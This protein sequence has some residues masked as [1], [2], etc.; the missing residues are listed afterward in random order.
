[1]RRFD[2]LPRLGIRPAAGA[3]VRAALDEALREAEVRSPGAVRVLDAGCGHKSPLVGLRPRI[4]LLVGVDLHR[5]DPPLPWIDD[6]AVV[7]LCRP[8]AGVPGGG[9]DIVLSSFT[10]EHFVDPDAALANL[11]RWMNPGG[12]IVLTT[13]N[14]R[15]PFV[16]GYVRIPAGPRLR[17]QRVLKASAADAHPIVGACNDPAA[18]RR[19]LRQAGFTGVRVETMPNLARAWGRHR[20]TFALGAAGDLLVQSM[21]SRRSTI[22]AIGH[23]PPS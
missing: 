21:P 16:D 1:M 8:G 23:V 20:T 14:R 3:R 15:H 12:T 17:L 22:L 5:P 10:L 13:V 2:L 19:A 11:R 6:F 18:V 4:A 9:F 7:D